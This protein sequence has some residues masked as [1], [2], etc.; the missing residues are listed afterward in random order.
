LNPY[1]RNEL[2]INPQPMIGQQFGPH[3]LTIQIADAVMKI[4]T[5]ELSWSSCV[6]MK[7]GNWG[8]EKYPSI[9][10]FNSHKILEKPSLSVL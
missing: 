6:L 10:V 4:N 5:I 7:S 2:S 8:A 3:H 1:K 9:S